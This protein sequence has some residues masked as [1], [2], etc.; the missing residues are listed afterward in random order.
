MNKLKMHSPD[1]T[2]ANID[3][4]AQ[5]FPNC[6]AE[7]LGADGVVQRSIDFDQLRQEL[8]TSIVEGPQE[9]YQLNWPGKREAL[10]TANAPIAKTLRPCREES[11]D[12]DATQ[13]LFI[14]GDNLDALKLLQETYLNKVK[15]IYIDPPYNTGNDFIYEDDF[16][17]DAES[18][19]RR[20]NQKDE[21]GNRLIANTDSNGRFH[22][23][24]L[25][26]IYSRLRLAR[27]LLSE[28]GV[29]FISIDE[30]EV[31]S[32]KRMC[33]EIFSEDNHV[34]TLIVKM[35]NVAGAS[36]GGED[37]KL[38]KNIEYLLAYAKDYSV[39]P[40]F[41]NAYTYTPIGELVQQY[42]DEDVSW[43]YT[44]ALVYEG[45]KEYVGSTVDG[46]GNEIKIY[47]RT[48]PVI[49]SINQIM[50][51]EGISEVAAYAKYSKKL[52][53]TQ[54]PQSSIRP[55]VMKKVQEIGAVS[56]LFS[57]E[58]VPRSGRNK[59]T[60][61][62]QFYKGDSFRLFAWLSDVSEE[63]NG[64]LCKKDLQGTL[65]DFVGETKNLAKEGGIAFPN[66]KKPL[67]MI[68]R[69]L[70]M[71]TNSDSLVLDFFAG[72]STTAH[73]VMKLNAEDGGSRKFIMVQ[74]PEPCEINV[75]ATDGVFKSIADISKERIRR[76]G[77]EIQSANAITAPNIDVGFR[78][79]KIDTSSMKD[80]Y[81]TP[82]TV[83]Q[84]QLIGMV[85]NIREDRTSED[86]L[87]QV[88]L[89]WGVDLALPI[90]QE[91]IAGKAV[92][93]VDGNALA[94]CFEEGISEEFVKLL[95]KREPLRAVFRDAGFASD[96]LKINVEQ[97]FKLMS[98]GTEVKTI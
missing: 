55:R 47:S 24:W 82:D 73:A 46:D 48:S 83:T 22:S 52:F 13:N 87:F 43:K 42:R 60:M 33:D 96:S 45:D 56:D 77:K 44:T 29:I 34:N 12:F 74:L 27:N 25:S 70:D 19:K 28:D 10:L 81:Y 80:V 37:K 9:R 61:Y 8:S 32:L 41:K 57:I 88:L 21:L 65:W 11:V 16:A 5:L 51:D 75:D 15:L 4:L 78:V 63:V 67:A 94:A 38:K 66:A 50:R 23:D 31:A 14:E 86:L 7:A 58:Y 84:E 76:A 89:D 93:F 92:F 95:A 26:M 53:Q 62:E 72:S 90:T 35:K 59:G 98:P 6:I 18:Y 39:F 1:L 2:Q 71:Q 85:S 17:V 79:L 97:I 64:V 36:G 69:L 49:K 54:M 20:S 68:R 91:A 3:K 40:S 30:G